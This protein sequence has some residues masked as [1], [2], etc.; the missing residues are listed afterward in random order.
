MSEK[1]TVQ[2]GRDSGTTESVVK[3][4]KITTEL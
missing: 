3:E 2:R 4:L 1:R